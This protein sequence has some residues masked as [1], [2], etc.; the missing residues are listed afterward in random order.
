MIFMLIFLD[1]VEHYSSKGAVVKSYLNVP[2]YEPKWMHRT[3]WYY[4]PYRY[5]SYTYDRPFAYY[6]HGYP[7]THYFL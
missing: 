4:S 6:Y 1:N 2:T 5:P 7:Y 3:W